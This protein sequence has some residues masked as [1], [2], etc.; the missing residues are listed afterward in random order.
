M[1]IILVNF[2]NDSIGTGNT[3]VLLELSTIVWRASTL[4]PN[5]NLVEP[6]VLAKEYIMETKQIYLIQKN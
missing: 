6:C 5:D 4:F 1:T 2:H 3:K